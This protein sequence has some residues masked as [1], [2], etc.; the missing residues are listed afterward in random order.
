MIPWLALVVWWFDSAACH[1]RK[2]R[3]AAARIAVSAF[4]MARMCYCDERQVAILTLIG[5]G[6]DAGSGH[7]MLQCCS[8]IYNDVT[9]TS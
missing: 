5:S 7:R 2:R 4:P 8:E 6:G 1:Q 3:D 9:T